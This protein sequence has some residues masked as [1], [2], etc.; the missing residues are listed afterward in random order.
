M[1]LGL[2]IKRRRNLLR[3]RYVRPFVFIHINKTGGE[4]V[5][6]ALGLVKEH[7]SARDKRDE[8]G[9]RH[10]DR[11]FKFSFVRNPWDRLVSLYSFR[12]VKDRI[13]EDDGTPLTFESWI[14]RAYGPAAGAPGLLN[15]EQVNWLSDEQG[16]IIVDFVGRFER[17]A[18]DFAQVAARL[19]RDVE[20]PHLNASQRGPYPDYYSDRTRQLV[21]QR[22]ANDIE[23]FGYEFGR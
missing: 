21:E 5:G 4:S 19:D 13:P 23:A 14:E 18:D 11:K 1:E 10:W 6:R 16:R 9:R 3:D 2:G 17:L 22:F 8:L 20:L 15:G 7:R 12:L